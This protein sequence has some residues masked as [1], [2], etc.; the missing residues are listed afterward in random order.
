MKDKKKLNNCRSRLKETHVKA[1]G[2]RLASELG[3]GGGKVA[4][5]GP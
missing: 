4:I 2:T 5:K 1:K 3:G